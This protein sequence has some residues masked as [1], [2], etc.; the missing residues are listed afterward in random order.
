MQFIFDGLKADVFG[1]NGSSG[2]SCQRWLGGDVG[3]RLTRSGGLGVPHTPLLNGLEGVQGDDS[4]FP[5]LVSAPTA[6]MR[7]LIF[8][9]ASSLLEFPVMT[10]ESAQSDVVCIHGA[11][12]LR[13]RMQP[14]F[15]I[16]AIIDRGHPLCARP[17]AFRGSRMSHAERLL[18][19]KRYWVTGQIG[20]QCFQI[21]R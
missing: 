11:A 15:S 19:P 16:N 8:A 6:T 5:A 2:A 3:C 7:P 10:L 9:S 4:E 1:V 13:T 14:S 20:G 12:D 17:C 18:A 21:G